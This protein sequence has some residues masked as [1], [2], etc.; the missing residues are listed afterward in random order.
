MPNALRSSILL[1]GTLV[2]ACSGAEAPAPEPGA[3][4][5]HAR[6]EVSA[7][8]REG[9]EPRV[10]AHAHFLRY[11]DIDA[12]AADTLAGRRS[13]VLEA[14]R[15]ELIE[16]DQRLDDA[17]AVVPTAGAES[18]RTVVA[19]MDA[20]E[21]L[22][23]VGGSTAGTMSPRLTPPLAPYV[24][25]VEYEELTLDPGPDPAV[26]AGTDIGVTGFGGEHVGP[27]DAIAT[28]PPAPENVR[29]E[30]G[31]DLTVRWDA[32]RTAADTELVVTAQRRG[33]R[34]LVSCRTA[35]D[36]LLV[37]FSRVLEQIPGD[38]PVEVTVE[39]RRRMPLAVPGVQWGELEVAARTVVTAP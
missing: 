8:L 3:A 11:H 10:V 32:A 5:T 7:D 38:G 39:R 37:L 27:F 16:P 23:T 6:V 19:H 18:A 28:L 1:A 14:G 15:C 13:T 25:G 22:I 20:G 12:D 26:P 17:L 31:A 33:L 9:A 36:G 34:S 21:L 35:D 2:A 29:V 24:S 30:V 4:Q